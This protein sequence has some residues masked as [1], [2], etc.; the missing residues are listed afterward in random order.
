METTILKLIVATPNG[1]LRARLVKVKDMLIPGTN[2]IQLPKNHYTT[3][4][5][6]KKFGVCFNMIKPYELDK[7]ERDEKT[8]LIRLV[9]PK[10]FYKF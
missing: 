7:L 1:N 8:N 3:E 10:F 5:I 2:Q 6:K 9:I 4:W